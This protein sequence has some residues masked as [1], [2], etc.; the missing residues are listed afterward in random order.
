MTISFD[1]MRLPFTC[2]QAVWIRVPQSIKAAVEIE[3]LSFRAGLHAAGHALL[4][5]VPL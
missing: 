2:K 5:V 4:N 3:K 1:F